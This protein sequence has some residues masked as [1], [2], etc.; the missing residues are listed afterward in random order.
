MFHAVLPCQGV[1]DAASAFWQSVTRAAAAVTD[2]L[3]MCTDKHSGD[4]TPHSCCSLQAAEQELLHVL[5]HL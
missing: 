4:T 3:S 2:V 5:H 1:P